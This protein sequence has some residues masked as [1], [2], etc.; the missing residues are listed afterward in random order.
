MTR[1]AT[2]VL[3]F[4]LPI[5]LVAL[6]LTVLAALQL[7]KARLESDVVRYL[8]Q[9][10]PDVKRFDEIG[11]RFGSSHVGMV[12]VE[13]P[14]V[15]SETSLT[16]IR[17]L[18]RLYQGLEGVDHVI[19]ITNMMDFKAKDSS[20]EVVKLVDPDAIPSDPATLAAL[21]THAMQK[22][23]VRGG[24][25]SEDSKVALIVC[26]LNDS[27]RRDLT[28]REIMSRT[29]ALVAQSALA[30]DTKIIF[31]GF[32]MTVV[33]IND[34]IMRDMQ[35]LIPLVALV[36]LGILFAM[37]R[38]LRGVLLPL[39]TVAFATLWAVGAMTALGFPI[40]MVS[41]IMPVVLLAVGS[42]YGIHMVSRYNEDAISGRSSAEVVSA[43]LRAVALPIL[44]AGVTT[45][46]GFATLATAT[47]TLIRD[48]GLLT[49][50]GV[51]LAVIA[52]ITLLP[53]ILSALPVKLGKASGPKAGEE[54]AGLGLIDA[55]LEKLARSVGARP[56][57]YILLA[58]VSGLVGTVGIPSIR[59]DVNMLAHFPK[60]SLP[61]RSEELLQD[62]FGGSAPLFLDVHGDMK[63][64]WVLKNLHRFGVQ[65]AA[66]EGAAR[67]SSLADVIADL[68][69]VMNGK[70][71]VPDTAE[72]IG[73]LWFFLDGQE[74]LEQMV[75]SDRKR[76]V[77]QARVD[78]HNSVVMRSVADHV[79]AL[80][81]KAA[82]TK[83]ARLLPEGEARLTW[84]REGIVAALDQRLSLGIGQ[85]PPPG[86]EAQ[87]PPPRESPLDQEA[88]AAKLLSFTQAP[89]PETSPAPA[90]AIEV[91]VRY[92]R[93]EENE[94]PFE[95][96][97]A[98][99]AQ[100]ALET[101]LRAPG[102]ETQRIEAGLIASLQA[103]LSEAKTG[104]VKEAEAAAQIAELLDDAEGIHLS[105]ESLHRVALAKAQRARVVQ[106]RAEM[107]RLAPE[108]AVK[109][110][111]PESLETLR[112]ELEG[113]LYTLYA[114]TGTT[115]P[116]GPAA[117][118]EQTGLHKINLTLNTALVAN[119]MESIVLA[120]VFVLVL[121][122]LQFKS[123]VG[124]LLAMIP[125][126]M[127][128]LVSFGLMAYA[129]IALDMATA[130]IASV[131]IGIGIDY[132]IH[133]LAR[134]KREIQEGND[135]SQAVEATIRTTGRAILTNTLSVALG[136]LVLI[137]SGMIPL[138][139]FGELVAL[140]MFLCALGALTTL[141]ATIL[142]TRGRYFQ[143][144]PQASK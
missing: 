54:K 138:R 44:A 42:A 123:L 79:D 69:F 99:K 83:G 90:D 9:G 143:S 105:A 48:F 129:D 101:V 89:P 56:W 111:S 97:L 8:P 126:A 59:T 26:N 43:A 109:A 88:I 57:T 53:A 7:P 118:F 122:I 81:E 47:M 117:T 10:D 116:E 144:K 13:L 49:A 65:I 127:A 51:L 136:F 68:N 3:R 77:L 85:G 17:D 29:D 115:T 142:L 66:L 91:A 32:P 28:A 22:D 19:S 140:N 11:Q 95:G 67:P 134:F 2:F 87:E 63:D 37:F 132:T 72:E 23:T 21:K 55:F 102:W 125:I 104:G 25:V 92:L 58:L 113:E 78:A 133:F 135:A 86:A 31:A 61:R 6:G 107:L 76:G 121:M 45:F 24:I 108:E 39:G 73:N 34:L 103:A 100:G 70:R 106:L 50:L 114:P 137:L 40:T 36:I 71:R 139:H 128:T 18:T 110:L 141:P 80:L 75:T 33:S 131:T 4:R 84:V 52:S 98:D 35:L 82:I 94:I 64:P 120:I 60:D 5:L 62:R 93:S 12:A 96:Q 124:G 119:Q 14:E 1:F 130:M 74:L 20:V 16:L 38:T 46:I 15:F 30:Q 112:E 27:R 41:A